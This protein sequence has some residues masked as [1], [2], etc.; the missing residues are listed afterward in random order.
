MTSFNPYVLSNADCF[1]MAMIMMRGMLRVREASHEKGGLRPIF[2]KSKK[3]F[4]LIK[5]GLI[6]LQA[7]R[8][9]SAEAKTK[10]PDF[11]GLWAAFKV[12]YDFT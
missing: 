6:L 4:T 11:R 1:R 5:G 2:Q 9:Q 12:C 10:S 7:D 3:I 8:R